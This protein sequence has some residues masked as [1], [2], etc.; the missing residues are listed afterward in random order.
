MTQRAEFDVAVS[1]GRG[2]EI[3]AAIRDLALRGGLP[4]QSLPGL[5]IRLIDDA[6]PQTLT[7]N[8]WPAIFRSVLGL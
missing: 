5:N 2:K 1:A 7:T 3:R 8:L 4:K 6:P